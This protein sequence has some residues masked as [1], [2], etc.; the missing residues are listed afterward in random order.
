MGGE[1]LGALGIDETMKFLRTESS[2][3]PKQSAHAVLNQLPSAREGDVQVIPGFGSYFGCTDSLI[4]KTAIKLMNLPGAG[5]TL[6]WANDFAQALRPHNMGWLPAG[7]AAAVFVDLGFQ[8][9]L[10]PGL[11]QLISASG[12]LAHGIELANKPI[13]SMPFISDENYVIE[14]ISNEKQS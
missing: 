10:G 6:S 12:L 13:T 8:P 2:N 11:F 5:K 4:G 1:Y 3:D 7:L 9:R 14:G